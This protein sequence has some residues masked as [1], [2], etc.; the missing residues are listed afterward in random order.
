MYKSLLRRKA[1]PC[2]CRVLASGQQLVKRCTLNSC[3]ADIEYHG[4]KTIGSTIPAVAA[5]ICEVRHCS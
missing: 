4:S 1:L 2:G 5:F 3:V